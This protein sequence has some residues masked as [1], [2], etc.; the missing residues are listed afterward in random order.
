MS[1]L[2]VVVLTIPDTAWREDLNG[3]RLLAIL[4]INGTFHH[5]EA[6]RVIEDDDGIQQ[7]ASEE[8]VETF[9]AMYAIGGEGPFDTVTMRGDE[10]VL[11]VTPFQ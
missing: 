3:D 5:L 7:A 2:P 10:Y 4:V 8:L 11:V 9:E 6:I 1:D